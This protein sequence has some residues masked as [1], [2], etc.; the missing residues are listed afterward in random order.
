MLYT[1]Q[2]MSKQKVTLTLPAELLEK[3][4]RRVPERKL[5]QYVTEALAERLAAEERAALRERLKEQYLVRAA[6]DRELAQEFF[7]AEQEAF[8]RVES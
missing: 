8:D 2:A 5:S 3:L 1:S 6:Q 4:R 7:P